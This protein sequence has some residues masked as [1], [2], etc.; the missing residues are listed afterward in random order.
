VGGNVLDALAIYVDFATVAQRLE[1]LGPVEWALLSLHQ[2][3]WHIWHDGD[4][5]FLM[6]TRV[7]PL[8]SGFKE[9]VGK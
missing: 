6:L 4:L 3:L 9:I 5:G 1:V 8:Y 2:A 7:L